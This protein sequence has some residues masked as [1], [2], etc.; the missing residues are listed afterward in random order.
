MHSA[1]RNAC[2]CVTLVP[3]ASAGADLVY[4]GTGEP[5]GQSQQ[6]GGHN[7]GYGILRAE[8]PATS[9][10][11]DPWTLEAR[12]LEGEGISRI[13]VEP[14]GT[15]VVAATTAGLFQRPATTTDP[16]PRVSAW[17][18]SHYT[19]SVTDVLWTAAGGAF[20]ARQWAWTSADQDVEHPDA[21]KRHIGA[22]LWVRA[23]GDAEF[24]LLPTPGTMQARGVLAAATPPTTVF[25]LNN[26]GR[27][28]APALFQ[29]SAPSG[30]TPTVQAVTGVPVTLVRGQGEYDLCLAIEPGGAT[31]ICVGGSYTMIVDPVNPNDVSYDGA[32]YRGTVSGTPPV[33]APVHIG[34]GAHADVHALV[35]AA[36]GARL[37]TGTDGGIFRSDAP[38]SRSGFYAR[39]DGLAIIQANYLATHPTCEGYLVCGLQD[40]GVIERSAPGAWSS[41]ALGD[42]GGVLLD[43][44]RPDRLLYQ[45]Y[46]GNWSNT[47]LKDATGG[48]LPQVSDENAASA[49]YSQPSAIV[50]TRGTGA[51]ATQVTQV[52]LPTTRVWYA[53]DFSRSWV[54]LPRGS[55]AVTPT[56]KK[57]QDR[58][59][60]PIRVCEWQT[61]DT[62]WILCEGQL[63]LLQRVPGS[64]SATS[65]GSWSRHSILDRGRKNKK[66]D[67]SIPDALKKATAWTDLAINLEPGGALRGS[68]GAV[69]L[70]TG[71]HP[72]DPSVDTLWWFDGTST[73]HRTL[74]RTQTPG[75]T[76]APVTA[77][78]ADRAHP[79]IVYV[80]T[81]IGVWR[82][83]RSFSGSTPS[84]RWEPMLNGLPEAC[85]E[86]LALDQY[87]TVRLLRAAIAARGVW[88]V[89]LGEDL[90]DLTYLRCH[91]DDLRYRA[92]AEEKARDLTTVRSWHGSPDVRPRLLLEAPP[93]PGDLPWRITKKPGSAEDLRRF[94]AAARSIFLD[95]RI[96]VN[97]RWDAY[98][99]ECLR[100]H[101]APVVAG[102]VTVDAGFWASVVTGSHATAAP[103]GAGNP[104]YTDLLEL[105]PMLGEGPN[106]RASMTVARKPAKIE[107]V[108][109]RRSPEPLDGAQVRVT[110][111]RWV[112][113]APSGRAD[114]WDSSTWRTAGPGNDVPWT[115]EV[116]EVLNSA[117]GTFTGSMTGGWAFVGPNA[118]ARRKTLVG[119]TLSALEPGIATFDLTFSGFASGRLVL[120]VAVI[121]DGATSNL[122]PAP[123]R[124][125][126]RGHAHVAVRSLRVL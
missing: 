29:V 118:A 61:E 104:T 36:A 1:H 51:A 39:N 54:T 124:D 70:A 107:V 82:G 106:A 52:L 50:H 5:D 92:V 125:L 101:G 76:P 126:A 115:P 46:N 119:Q 103:W 32:I 99:D 12:N 59:R 28:T 22:G 55:S 60:E 21:A 90:E 9:T 110:L 42:G 67:T 25:G 98:L 6:P 71:G 75:G 65:A 66:S 14:A 100:E 105:G 24:T 17:P 83:T 40:N 56:Y 16:W 113:P 78:L 73:W 30:A 86:D 58:L 15:A 111:L 47:P 120:L 7:R 35:Y 8:H 96:R 18:F 122:T 19:K 74:L 112:D 38:A 79:E 3:G 88:E 45:Y 37:Y 94:Q 97:G 81:T 53:E 121:S 117:G 80:G 77:V 49:F 48:W 95:Q 27:T 64:D 123:L 89:R 13:A 102:Q 43:P 63:F 68:R 62:A 87:D 57:D 116:N 85:V 2:G 114:P 44:R 26:T 72:T 10:A 11:D 69:Y 33:F 93:T 31:T 20:P 108:V 34:T 23:I 84:W 91:D 4:V 41:R 109:H